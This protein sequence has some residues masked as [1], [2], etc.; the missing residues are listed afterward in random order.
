MA[1]ENAISFW[2]AIGSAEQ[3]RPP[4]EP[5]AQ[6]TAAGR[7]KGLAHWPSDPWSTALVIPL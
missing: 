6:L 7:W 3:I 2:D 5:L 4:G 1:K